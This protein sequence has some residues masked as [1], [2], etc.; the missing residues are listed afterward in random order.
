MTFLFVCTDKQALTHNNCF[1][2]ENNGNN[3]SSS[4]AITSA[5]TGTLAN[6]NGT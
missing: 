2:I 6:G 1:T 5:D 3:S 4:A